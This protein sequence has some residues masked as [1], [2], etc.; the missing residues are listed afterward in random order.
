[1]EYLNILQNSFRDLQNYTT[2]KR[3]N[4]VT[5][6]NYS[7]RD[8]QNYTTLKRLGGSMNDKISFR[9]LQNYTTLKPQIKFEA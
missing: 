1:M 4:G 7:F 6:P 8:L 2:L 9:D 3:R 5:L